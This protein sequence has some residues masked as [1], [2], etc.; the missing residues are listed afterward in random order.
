MATNAYAARRQFTTLVGVLRQEYAALAWL[1]FK[2]SQTALLTDA[3]EA[4]FLALI[5]DDVDDIADELGTIAIARAMV[6]DELCEALGWRNDAMTVSDLIEAAPDDI[7]P[8]LRSLRIQ[9][10]ELA[11]GLAATAAHGSAAAEER[12]TA[13]RRAVAGIEMSAG[14]GSSDHLRG[15]VSV[16]AS[17]TTFDT[18]S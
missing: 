1:A 3:H 14:P 7:A 9:L 12:L 10:H 11:G 6:V 4:R 16:A 13:I 15:T 18:L 5:T 2:I 17:A 8:V